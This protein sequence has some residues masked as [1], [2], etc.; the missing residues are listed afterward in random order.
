MIV[1][2][3]IGCIVQYHLIWKEHFRASYMRDVAWHTQFGV[4]PLYRFTYERKYNCD[5]N[6]D[7][8]NVNISTYFVHV[9]EWLYC[10]R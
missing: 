2:K 9:F 4:P 8:N 6:F 5:T 10:I 7:I 3:P 1:R